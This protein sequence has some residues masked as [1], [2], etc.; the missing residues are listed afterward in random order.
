MTRWHKLLKR[1]L[2]GLHVPGEGVPRSEGLVP[3]FHVKQA[4]EPQRK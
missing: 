4:A 3:A 2:P 1:A